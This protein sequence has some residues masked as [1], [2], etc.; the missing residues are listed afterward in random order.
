MSLAPVPAGATVDRAT[1]DRLT[2]DLEAVRAQL[3]PKASVAE[4]R[5]FAQV[6]ARLELDPF[7][8][9]IALMPRWSTEVGRFVSRPTITVA[10]RRTIASRTGRLEGIE[11][12]EWT[13]PRDEVGEL[14]WL[15]PWPDEVGPPYAAR[16]LVHVAGWKV[17]ANGTAKW[18]EFH[19]V[20][21]KG[22]LTPTWD[23]MPAHMLGKVAE[24]MALRRGFPEV[25]VAVDYAGY[26][27]GAL[28]PDDADAVGEA[29]ADAAAPA[30]VAL[31]GR[32]LGD[33][34]VSFGDLEIW[35]GPPPS[36]DDLGDLTAEEAR[37]VIDALKTMARERA[38]GAE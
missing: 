31:I 12:P 37:A 18:S 4:L 15:D 8:G 9:Q 38:T 16:V 29:E 17:P 2:A 13:G 28:D 34:G 27:L 32:M 6:A 5:V 10:G 26:D 11:G 3:A 19:Q 20:D 35:N 22:R 23:R 1:V 30:Q 33:L 36:I 24:A 14:R 21:N 7:S 25:A